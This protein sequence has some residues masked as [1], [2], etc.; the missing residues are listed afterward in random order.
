M[1]YLKIIMSMSVLLLFGL[2]GCSDD[3]SPT[4]PGG[5]GGGGG[6][7]DQFDQASAL[8][9]AQSAAP[10]A[11]GMVESI[12]SI[13][14]GVDNKQGS[15]NWNASEERWESDYM[16]DV[17][18]YSYDWMYTVQ[19]LDGDG[20]PQQESAGASSLTH[21]MTGT[22]GSDINQGGYNIV[23]DF[24]YNYST[25]IS[26]LGSATHVMTGAGGYSIDY[27]YS[28]NG[29]NQVA[30]YVVEWETLSPGV[31]VPATGGCPTGTIQYKFNPFEMDVVFNGTSTASVGMV[32]GNGGNVPM[33]PNSYS[34]SC[35]TK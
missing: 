7:G 5:G 35:N 13:A 10:Q 27:T 31:S 12:S 15:Y 22:G 30:D 24:N 9:Q 29:V 16:A 17:G 2:V 3:D 19:Y 6:G 23:Y 32:D 25:T 34:L 28:G 1:D 4:D 18:G 26:G 21:S 33:N 14:A 8:A 20:N 11:V